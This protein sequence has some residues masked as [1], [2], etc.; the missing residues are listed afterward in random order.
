PGKAGETI[1]CLYFKRR[2]RVSHPHTLAALLSERAS[3]AFSGLFLAFAVLYTFDAYRYIGLA[4][5][6]LMFS[7]IIIINQ[8]SLIL[9]ITAVLQRIDLPLVR[10]LV[11][12]I[13]HFIQH[14]SSLLSPG[15]LITSI[16]IGL[17]S[18][19]AEALAFS[20]LVHA[21]G[22]DVSTLL[23]M[24]IFAISMIGGAISFLPGGVGAAEGI[25]AGLLIL[26][27]LDSAEALAATLICR[28]TTLWFAVIIGVVALTYLEH[29]PTRNNPQE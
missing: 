17:V 11:D 25:M 15:V 27:G 3:D 7:I 18:W 2:H 14:S 22:H 10:R 4:V 12:G 29:Q 20:W 24:S 26:V 9:K 8:P 1:R 28:L 16:G 5:F 23:L 6:L 21:M 19:S 13:P